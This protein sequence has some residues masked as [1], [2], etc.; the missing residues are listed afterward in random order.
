M[1]YIDKSCILEYTRG[2]DSSIPAACGGEHV[3]SLPLELE[4]SVPPIFV[5]FHSG[6]SQSTDNQR[7][8]F[9]LRRDL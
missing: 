5:G 6:G 1:I 7:H 8:S 9:I 3:S 2:C 4:L